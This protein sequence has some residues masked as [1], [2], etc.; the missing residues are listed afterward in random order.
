MAAGRQLAAAAGRRAASALTNQASSFLP[1][2][3][4]P[5]EYY[6]VL[7]SCLAVVPAFASDAYYVNKVR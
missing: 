7:H 5:Q 2:P 1:L 4:Q 3:P 6:E